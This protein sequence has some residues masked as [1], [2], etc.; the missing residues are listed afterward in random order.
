[1]DALLTKLC[2]LH[3]IDMGDWDGMYFDEIKTNFPEEYRRRGLDLAAFAPP[4]GESFAACQKRAA[5][6]FRN[7]L[8]SSNGNIAIVS[9]A[10]FNR[11]LLCSICSIDLKELFSISQPF[12]CVNFLLL[13]NGVCSV[14][15]I[16]DKVGEDN[17]LGE[18]NP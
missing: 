9:H 6:I 8:I 11:A 16:G 1:M 15:K 14:Q 3:E 18:E 12:G 17:G 5:K 2:G 7:I 13:H 4:N 10:G